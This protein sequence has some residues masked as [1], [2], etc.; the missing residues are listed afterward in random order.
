MT[1]HWDDANTEHIA[2]HDVE[3]EE[4]EEAATDPDRVAA[5]AYR[6]QSGERRQAMT[7]RTEDGRILTVILTRRGDLF[8]VVTAREASPSERRA[9]RR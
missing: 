8:R 6:S 9:Y 3:P 4:A 7:G 5:P 2:R 1:F